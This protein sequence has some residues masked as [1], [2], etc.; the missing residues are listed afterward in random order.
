MGRPRKKKQETA[1]EEI[2]NEA[3]PT[4]EENPQVEI[5]PTEEPIETPAEATVEEIAED[6]A[7]PRLV[8]KKEEE[9][10]VKRVVYQNA[11]DQMM[12][13]IHLYSQRT[14]VT[15]GNGKK[16]VFN[17][18]GERFSIS[19]REFEQEFATSPV[20]E[21]LLQQKILAIGE[22]CPK[23]IRER[24]DID[25]SAKELITPERYR[26]LLSLEK[27]EVVELFESLC[28]EH[29]QLMAKIF[30]DDFESN[31]GRNCQRDK[32][33]A[34]NDVSKKYVSAGEKGMFAAILQAISDKEE[35]DY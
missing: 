19:V 2:K 7:E 17:R 20:G 23:E 4:V 35:A 27:D 1:P 22:D 25:Y 34:L 10:P 3:M 28:F 24:L 33:K 13:V 29:K 16:K 9:P 26:T 11:G 32:I 6:R 8:E 15:Y 31:E 18:F 21:A 5:A 30:A 12:T 14:P